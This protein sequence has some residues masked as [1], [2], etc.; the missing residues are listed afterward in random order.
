MCFGTKV[1]LLSAAHQ[2]EWRSAA[3]SQSL[4]TRSLKGSTDG[5]MLLSPSPQNT[6]REI[7]ESIPA[8]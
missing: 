2:V 5:R 1:G 6:H 7:R 3:P 8:S 4:V